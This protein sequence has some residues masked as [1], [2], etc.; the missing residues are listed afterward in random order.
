MRSLISLAC[1]AR[2]AL[3]NFKALWF[4]A[5]NGNVVVPSSP[6]L[7]SYSPPCGPSPFLQPP[8]LASDLFFLR[9][10]GSSKRNPTIPAENS[11]NLRNSMWSSLL[12]VTWTRYLEYLKNRKSRSQRWNIFAWCKTI[13]EGT[14]SRKYFLFHDFSWARE[15]GGYIFLKGEEKKYLVSSRVIYDTNG[16]FSTF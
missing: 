7:D 6:F 12:N 10:E 5:R 13:C 1:V 11:R 2:T 8:L 16:I 15:N 4:T 14:E 3:A 9:P